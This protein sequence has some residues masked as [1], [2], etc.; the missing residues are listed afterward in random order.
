LRRA[1]RGRAPSTGAGGAALPSRL[2]PLITGA[3]ATVVILL[4][5]GGFNVFT[6]VLL[7]IGN[8]RC[9]RSRCR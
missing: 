5:I 9:S 3:L 2:A 6:S 8:D 1:A 4:V 7:M